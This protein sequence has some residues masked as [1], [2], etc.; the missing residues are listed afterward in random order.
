VK[1]NIFDTQYIAI[2]F[3][4]LFNPKLQCITLQVDLFAYNL[5]LAK[6][7]KLCNDAQNPLPQLPTL[8]THPHLNI[9]NKYKHPIFKHK[10]KKNHQPPSP[11]AAAP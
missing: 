8:S 2:L 5:T 9:E 11:P 1:F 7:V 6:K 10:K 3:L 4:L